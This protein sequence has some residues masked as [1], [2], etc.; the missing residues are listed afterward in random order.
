MGRTK[1]PEESTGGRQAGD[2]A[3][4]ERGGREAGGGSGPRGSLSQRPEMA[5]RG[6]PHR[7][8]PREQHRRNKPLYRR[9]GPRVE[10]GRNAS[11]KEV[12]DAAG[13]IRGGRFRFGRSVRR[14]LGWREVPAARV[15]A[16]MTVAFVRGRGG[17]QPSV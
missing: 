4:P 5:R 7:L 15:G 17:V 6:A 8:G 2:N 12:D 13:V 16:S 1:R 3:P 14:G 11:G 9:Q 10:Q